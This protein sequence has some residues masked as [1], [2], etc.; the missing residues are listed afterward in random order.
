MLVKIY[1]IRRLGEF[2]AKNKEKLETVERNYSADSVNEFVKEKSFEAGNFQVNVKLKDE[3]IQ[4][5]KINGDYF[6][7]KNIIE[8][9]NAF[10][11]IK[12]DRKLMGRVL[13]SYPVREYIEKMKNRD[14]LAIFFEQKRMSKP[15]YLKINM[16]DLNKETAK[17][18]A[19]LKQNNLYTVCQEASCPNQLECF[20]SKTA[21]F[22][23][24]GNKCSRNCKFC[25]VENG[26][27]LVVDPNEPENIVKTIKLMDLKHVV[28]TSVTRDDLEDYGSGQ[29]VKC[30]ELIQK[31]SPDTTIE[32]LIPDFMGDY[33]AIK[34]VVDANPDVVNHNLETIQRL[35]D[36]F[37]DNAD[38]ERSLHVLNTVKQINPKIL[39]KSGIMV[40]IGETVDEVLM[41][42]DDLRKINC[43]IM[44]IGQYLRPSKEHLEVTEYVSL[45]T[46]D[47]YKKK[48]TEKGF[49]YIASGPLV[50]SSYQ[51]LK[52]FKGE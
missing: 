35:Y 43:D 24:L 16:A 4:D 26:R 28:I 14:F 25:D 17:I 6:S 50:R 15:D 23:I 9:E 33:N 39:T 29:F 34:R 12:Y 47:I 2:M 52:Q 11:G 32:V 5:I 1:W 30:I 42:M 13:K 7:L 45:E 36:G 3:M 22:M 51:A 49:S 21:T 44:T 19:L 46:F 41:L 8:F 10:I 37:R 48:G 38:Y 40:G 20:S 31:E 18:R 27:P